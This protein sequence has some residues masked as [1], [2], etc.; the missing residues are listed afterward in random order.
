MDQAGSLVRGMRMRHVVHVQRMSSA[1]AA[2]S[3][4]ASPPPC[5]VPPP[6]LYRLPPCNAQSLSATCAHPPVHT[7][8]VHRGKVGAHWRLQLRQ[9]SALAPLHRRPVRPCQ[10]FDCLGDSAASSTMLLRY[11]RTL[12]T[13]HLSP[14]PLI[15][16]S[17]SLAVHRWR[18][19][20][21]SSIWGRRRS[22][23]SSSTPPARSASRRSPHR[24]IGRVRRVHGLSPHLQH[25]QPGD[26]Q[27]TL[28]QNAII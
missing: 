6:L 4:R 11:H 22:A 23:S 10:P 20:P 15:H 12:R 1:S 26:G 17:D 7:T 5:C 25:A 14:S 13:C 16:P 18:S 24:T 28:H 19:P 8:H 2:L 27:H 21:R 3:P 9:D